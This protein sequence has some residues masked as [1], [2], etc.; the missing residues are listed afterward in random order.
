MNIGQ[1]RF[2]TPLVEYYHVKRGRMNSELK[3][4]K[5][6][7]WDYEH[8]QDAA[9]LGVTNPGKI[10]AADPIQAED[11]PTI[12]ID[13]LELVASLKPA[14]SVHCV[15]K[16]SL[17]NLPAP[18]VAQP[19]E[20]QRSLSEW[21]QIWWDGIR[22]GYLSLSLSPI[23]LGT[24]LAWTQTVHAQTPLGQLDLAHLLGSIVLAF[25]IQIAG[26]LI[27][28][29]YDYVRGIDTG[30]ILGS[31]GLIQQR[32]VKPTLV[33]MIGLILLGMGTIFGLIFSIGRGSLML[34]LFG[35][36]IILG[37]YFYSAPPRP[38]SSIALGEISGFILFGPLLTL[39]AYMAQ[40]GSSLPASAFIYSL[41]PGLLAMAV[42]HTN[43]IRDRETDANSQKLTLVHFM[44]LRASRIIYL[45][46]LFIAYSI[47]GVL[48]VIHQG[49]HLIL[50]TFLAL[51]PLVIVISGIIR[52][53]ASAGFHLVMRE[54]LRI[55]IYF[56]L[57]LIAG[58]VLT[59]LIPV[60]PH[61][62]AHLL[63]F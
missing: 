55:E 37:A 32:Y 46:L 26:H 47:I 8:E 31:G 63:P 36:L 4:T 62:P 41:P 52:T 30:N 49:P 45:L 28:D 1:K 23:L 6:T 33:L 43:N 20:Y 15:D 9:S 24:T 16:T 58:L 21:L 19:S 10:V 3:Q 56:V 59:A 34:Y 11:V 54:T 27:N 51:P 35:L 42:I 25:L 57:L 29:Y 48:G 2:F 50:I 40:T 38:L 44:G 39:G 22:P 13:S 17:P 7:P 5:T 60:L 61:V 53:T 12:P 14:I 18:L